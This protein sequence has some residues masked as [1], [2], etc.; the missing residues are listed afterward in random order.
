MAAP[1]LKPRL[2]ERLIEAGLLNQTQLDLALREQKRLGGFIG[3]IF[4]DLGF[5]QGEI[6]SSFL[7]REAGTQTVNLV[8]VVIDKAIMQLVPLETAKRL[9]VVPLSRE[10]QTL[11]VAM[12]D[13]FDVPAVDTM[14]RITGLK[15]KVLTA[16]ERD[17]LNCLELQYS[18]QDDV[19]QSIDELLKQG[20][21]R[22]SGAEEE[23]AFGGTRGGDPPVIR[24]VDQIIT[25]AVNNRA[26]DIHFEPEDKVMR[27][28]M[29]I[30][31][32]LYQ[33]VLIPKAMQS[34]VIARLKIMG[35]L[36]VAETRIPQDGRA[37]VEVGRREVN[38]RISSMPVAFGE[39][40]VLRILDPTVQ[41]LQLQ[42]LGLSDED[43][44]S[45]T[46]SLKRPYGIILVCGPTGSGK[47]STL[48]AALS[49][50]SSMEHAV[51]TL[52]DPIEYRLPVI[53][54]TQIKEEIGMTFATGLRALLRQDPDII[55]VGETR[56]TETAQLMVRA[57]LTGHLVFST[58]HTNDAATAIPRLVDM[59][60]EPYLLPDSLAGIMAQRLIRTI[61]N[62]CKQ[63]VERG[64][65]VFAD[66]KIEPPPGWPV[67]LFR[68]AGCPECKGTGYKGR[69]GVFEFMRVDAR[70][71]D[72]IV[73]R[74]GAPIFARLGR[75][76]EMRT[77]FED[78]LRKALHGLTTIE[79]VLRVTRLA[80]G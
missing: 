77:M 44:K 31:G 5:V 43:Y 6:I 15:I 1:K 19:E 70:F 7:A 3:D 24:L 59:G 64:E 51:Y 27:I 61:C 52:E 37:T 17:I 25:R 80:T 50:I 68:G 30:D 74:A 2:G 16:S 8:R 20:P 18:Q 63:P 26:S 14:E 21:E 75:E 10:D 29:R 72:P 71:H 33:D 28:R 55:L 39:N 76:N 11:T 40:L 66:L 45:F 57:A 73:Q 60:V 67:Q 32:V 38:L 79:E 56:D 58:L 22:L 41:V 9:R 49:E 65:K 23:G 69:I 42:A 53:R 54:Q 48:Y 47:T 4:V 13:P 62:N 34:P 78:G 36:D 35:D 12:S 46:L